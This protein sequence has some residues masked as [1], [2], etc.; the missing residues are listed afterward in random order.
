MFLIALIAALALAS[1]HAKPTYARRRR[2]RPYGKGK[3]QPR[4]KIKKESLGK[5]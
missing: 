3:R 2:L 4:K 5:Y 1:S